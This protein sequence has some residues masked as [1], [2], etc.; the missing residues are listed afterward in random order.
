MAKIKWQLFFRTRCILDPKMNLFSHSATI[1]KQTRQLS[2]IR[3][4]CSPLR[5]E[6][7][8]IIPKQTKLTKLMYTGTESMQS[9]R[10]ARQP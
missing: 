7:K 9:Y 1:L 2:F 5:Q 4:C 8:S 3:L 6:R 10:V